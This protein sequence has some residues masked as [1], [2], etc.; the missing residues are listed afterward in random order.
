[1]ILLVSLVLLSILMVGSDASA[2]GI[3]VMV[4]SDDIADVAGDVVGDSVLVDGLRG[5]VV[6]G[7]GL[8]LVWLFGTLG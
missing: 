4:L 1:M 5:G 3:L 2:L 6:K 8:E 7:S